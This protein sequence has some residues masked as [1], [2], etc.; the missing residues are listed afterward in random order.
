MEQLVCQLPVRTDRLHA[1][2]VLIP[3]HC[4]ETPESPSN[5]LPLLSAAATDGVTHGDDGPRAGMLPRGVR[6]GLSPFDDASRMV[7]SIRS[8]GWATVLP[9]REEDKRLAGGSKS[10]SSPRHS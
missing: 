10:R 1:G 3:G 6:H 5:E 4:F 2:D 8:A 9:G 7:P